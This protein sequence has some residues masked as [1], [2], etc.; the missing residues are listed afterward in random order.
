[1]GSKVSSG[2]K[3]RVFTPDKTRAMIS[4]LTTLKT[5]LTKNV[6]TNIKQEKQRRLISIQDMCKMY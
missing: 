3:T 5:F 1:M 4:F 2:L 6:T